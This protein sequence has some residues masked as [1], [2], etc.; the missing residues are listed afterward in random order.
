MVNKY[1]KR[2]SILDKY[3]DVQSQSDSENFVKAG[4]GSDLILNT[5]YG[6]GSDLI[7]KTGS[8]YEQDTWIRNPGVIVMVSL[9]FVPLN[10]ITE[11]NFKTCTQDYPPYKG[12]K[13]ND[14]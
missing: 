7:S 1:C 10:M 14:Q 8:A 3:L 9:Y 13:I 12:K 11:L 4:S 6:S 5:G 2:S